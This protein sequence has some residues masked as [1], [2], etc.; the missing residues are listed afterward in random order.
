MMALDSRCIARS[1]TTGDKFSL[2][3][4]SRGQVVG[5]SCVNNAREFTSLK[6]LITGDSLPDRSALADP[7]IDLRNLIARTASQPA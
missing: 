2:I 6:R 1:L 7:G 3:H 4:L 5:A